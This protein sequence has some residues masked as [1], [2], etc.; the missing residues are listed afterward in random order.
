M[1]ILVTAGA[2]WVKIDDVRI[3]T[4]RFTGKTGRLISQGLEK[5]GHSVT[6]LINPHC[7]E[8]VKNLEIVNFSYFEEFRRAIINLLKQNHFDAIIHTAAVSDYKVVKASRGK[9]P[10]G[11]EVL[12]LELIPTEKIIKRIKRLAKKTLLIQFKMEAKL[13]GLVDAAY[14]SLIDNKSD[15]VVANALIDLK[16]GYK[17]YIIDKDK[18]VVPVY[19]REELMKGLDKIVR[20]YKL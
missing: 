6:L 5:R 8:D 3:L 4:N 19:S 2:T 18:Q 15:F 16:K 9:I 10:S 20:S 13:K 11:K 1:K 12:D 17:G 7:I 14:N